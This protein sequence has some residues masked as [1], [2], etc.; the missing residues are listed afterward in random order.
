[1]KGT[2]AGILLTIGFLVRL[3]GGAMISATL[4]GSS[5]G[6]EE[7]IMLVNLIFLVFWMSGSFLLAVHLKLD[8]LWGFAGFFFIFGLIAMYMASPERRERRARRKYPF[9]D[10]NYGAK[11]ERRERR[12]DDERKPRTYDY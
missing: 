7:G 11:G 4:R 5:A 3:I 8:F 1:M 12:R 6:V 2:L 9:D 10:P